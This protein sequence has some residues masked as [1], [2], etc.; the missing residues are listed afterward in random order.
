MKVAAFQQGEDV[1]VGVVDPDGTVRSAGE[2]NAFWRDPQAALRAVK[3]DAVG[4]LDTLQQRPAVPLTAR[5]ICVGLNYRLHAQETGSPIPT[6]PIIFARWACTLST[7]GEP[8]PQIGEKFDW[9]VELGAVIGRRM[10]RV[11]AEQAS[12]G[13]FGYV[14]FNDLSAREF[15][16]ETPQWTMGKNSDASG[17]MSPIVTPDETGDPADGLRVTTRVNGETMQDSTTADMIFSVPELIAHV[18]KVMT[19]EPG[20]LIV[21]GTP[22]GVGLATGRFLKPG[23]EVEIEVERIGRVRTPIVETPPAIA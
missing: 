2:I 22:S 6:V 19:L 14:A 11:T 7:D 9:E 3:Q 13:I 15:Q 4:G 23:D 1:I 5:V 17:P 20:D 10:F 12:A 16:M 18:S 21:T 8:A